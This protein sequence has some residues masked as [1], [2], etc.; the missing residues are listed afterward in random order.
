MSLINL[1]SIFDDELRERVELF[2]D[3]Q[4]LNVNQ[5]KLD[6]NNNQFIPQSHGF[7]V[8]INP[9]T[10]DTLLRGQIYEPVGSLNSTVSQEIF[11][12]NKEESDKLKQPYITETFDPRIQKNDAIKPFINTNLSI[13]S[14]QYGQQRLASLP[15]DFSTAVGNND[16]AF[17]P[18]GQ[19]GKSPLDGMSWESLYESDHAPK[20]NPSHRGLTP[21]NYPNVNRDNLNI[22]SHTELTYSVNSE[23]LNQIGY[24]DTED[25]IDQITEKF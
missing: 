22:K 13:N 19:L 8:N 5:S 17:T 21:I 3:N 18:L 24:I 16:S 1:K 7:D 15:T 6:Y 4:V 10:L 20:D 23:V 25:F 11:F 2:L 12:V 14:R 9:P